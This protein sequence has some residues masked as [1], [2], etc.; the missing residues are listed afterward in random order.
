MQLTRFTDLG[1]RV[2]MR[3]AVAPGGGGLTTSQVAEDLSIP[4]THTAKVVARLSELGMVQ[5]RRGRGG[6]LS[7][8][9]TARRTTAGWLARALEGEGEVVT[10]EGDRPCPLR[11][12]CLLRTALR[13]AQD[14]FYATLDTVTIDDLSATPTPFTPLT[15]APPAPAGTPTA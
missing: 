3:L 2:V 8:T 6:G 15:L 11:N 12:G 10:C 14:A 4:Y 13:R 1:L 9:D 5:A 7:I